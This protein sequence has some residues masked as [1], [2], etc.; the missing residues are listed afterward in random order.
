MQGTHNYGKQC[1]TSIQYTGNG[2]NTD[3]HLSCCM[4][5]KQVRITDA[6]A[7]IRGS[8]TLTVTTSDFFYTSA[9]QGKSITVNGAGANGANL[10]TTINTRTSGT[11]V[12]LT[13]AASTTVSNATITVTTGLFGTAMKN[14]DDIEVYVDGVKQ[15]YTTHYTVLLNV[16]DA[17]NK[18]GTVQFV[19]APASASTITIVRDVELSRTTDFQR[20]GALT[21]KDLNAEFDNIVMALQDNIESAHLKFPD[22]L[23]SRSNLTHL[24]QTE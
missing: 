15:T 20:G 22:E 12:E 2:N 11:V 23:V 7:P 14:T 19:T 3:L 10:E 21:S 16:G 17:S 24:W 9:L 13:N 4:H 1:N 18:N 8:T 5:Y 6:T